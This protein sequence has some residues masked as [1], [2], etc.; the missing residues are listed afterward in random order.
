MFQDT[1]TQETVHFAGFLLI[2][3]RHIDLGHDIHRD[4]YF[5]AFRNYLVRP[6][7]RIH[8]IGIHTCVIEYVH[9]G[10]FKHLKFRHRTQVEVGMSYKKQ[11]T[12]I[13]RLK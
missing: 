7:A 6:G 10:G 13:H 1:P 11:R 5:S 12:T 3:F 2:G 9:L 8:A 4:G